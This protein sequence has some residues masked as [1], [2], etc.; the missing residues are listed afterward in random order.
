MT[1]ALSDNELAS[2]S[3]AE[4]RALHNRV[5]R[6]IDN[7]EAE[8]LRRA[9]VELD[10]KARELGFTLDEVVSAKAV[11]SRTAGKAKYANPADRS[12]TW[13]GRGRQPRWFAEALASGRSKQ[14]MEV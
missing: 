2:L 14:S 5:G 1:T 4:L 11:R 6:A 13:S 12:Q 3:L 8:R 7:Y 9:R 10:Q